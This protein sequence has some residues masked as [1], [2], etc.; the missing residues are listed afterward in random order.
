M[1]Y[2][3]VAGYKEGTLDSR[4]KIDELRLKKGWTLSKLAKESGLSKT[5]VY[6]WY[7]EKNFV[8]SRD[9]IEDVCLAL[10]VSLAEFYSEVEVDK[11][12][13]RQMRLLEL[14]EKVPE[15]KKDTI[16]EIVKSFAE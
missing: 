11:L 4:K 13:E 14:F 2:H 16:L 9:T 5:T 1:H 3:I 6:N 10:D 15:K 12:D 7:N 8:P